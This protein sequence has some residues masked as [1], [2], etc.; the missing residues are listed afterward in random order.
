MTW[1]YDISTDRSSMD[2]YDHTGSL[3]TTIANDGTGFSIPNDVL[4]VMYDELQTALSNNNNTRAIKI[5]ADAA[6]EQINEG[7][8]A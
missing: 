5:S 2:V 6:C 8:P 1:Y 3:I 7:T 4:D